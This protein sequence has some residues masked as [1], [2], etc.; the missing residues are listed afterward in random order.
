MSNCP[1]CNTVIAADARRCPACGKSLTARTAMSMATPPA[2]ASGPASTP[3]SASS[4]STAEPSY[5]RTDAQKRRTDMIVNLLVGLSCGL[6]GALVSI[7]CA[8]RILVKHAD[9]PILWIVFILI[10]LGLGYYYGTRQARIDRKAP[11]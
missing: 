2:A 7:F 1:F 3:A 8:R 11:Y 5:K 10:G 4:A 6:I 9:N